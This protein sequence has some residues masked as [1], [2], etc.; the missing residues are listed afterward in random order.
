M[1]DSLS[2]FPGLYFLT[3]CTRLVHRAGSSLCLTGYASHAARCAVELLNSQ[4]RM[5]SIA[6]LE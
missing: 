5:S 4:D 1:R 6:I 2:Y 3:I